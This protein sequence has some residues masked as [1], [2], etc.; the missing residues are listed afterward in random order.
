MLFRAHFIAMA[1]FSYVSVNSSQSQCFYF[2]GKEW[3]ND[4]LGFSL[5][6]QHKKLAVFEVFILK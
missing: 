1:M 4:L 5:C 6:M 2:G 3:G